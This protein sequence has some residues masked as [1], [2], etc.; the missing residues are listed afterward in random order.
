M[1]INLQKR[2]TDAQT[3]NLPRFSQPNLVTACYFLKVVLQQAFFIQ[4]L[5]GNQIIRLS[6]DGLTILEKPLLPFSECI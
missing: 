3:H 1:Y 6:N 5:L 2:W 4:Q